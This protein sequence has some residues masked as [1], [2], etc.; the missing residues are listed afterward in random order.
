MH[1]AYHTA[2]ISWLSQLEE[3]S[4]VNAE[5]SDKPNPLATIASNFLASPERD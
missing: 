4:G 5:T 1:F 3:E 2:L